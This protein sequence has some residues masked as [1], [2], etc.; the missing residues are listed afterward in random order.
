MVLVDP[1][2]VLALL[3]MNHEGKKTEQYIVKDI[4]P[5]FTDKVATTLTQ[6]TV[7]LLEAVT[8]T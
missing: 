5:N 7:T 3:L 4:N 1:A 2:K 6:Q 8:D